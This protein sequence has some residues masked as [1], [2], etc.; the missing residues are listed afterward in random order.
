MDNFMNSKQYMYSLLLI[1]QLL[2]PRYVPQSLVESQLNVKK[3][4]LKQ[5]KR[6]HFKLFY[7]MKNTSLLCC[8]LFQAESKETGASKGCGERVG[9][10]AA[11]AGCVGCPEA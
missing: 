4:P 7:Q 11:V 9:R 2:L 8:L 1:E 3:T 6:K 10:G 5:E